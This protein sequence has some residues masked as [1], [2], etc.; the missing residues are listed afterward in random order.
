M[1]DESGAAKGCDVRVVGE[2][3]FARCGDGGVAQSV[4]LSVVDVGLGSAVWRRGVCGCW[5]RGRP[6]QEQFI[7]P[8]VEKVS[9]MTYP[10]FLDD[11]GGRWWQVGVA[12]KGDWGEFVPL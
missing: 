10:V 6:L 9:V 1:L 3:G 11:A 7:I 8:C 2:R 4:R 5:G 12:L